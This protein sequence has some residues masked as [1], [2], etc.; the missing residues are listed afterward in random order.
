MFWSLFG[1][2]KVNTRE[3][4]SICPLVYDGE[5]YIAGVEGKDKRDWNLL[6]LDGFKKGWK[7]T[8]AGAAIGYVKVRKAINIVVENFRSREDV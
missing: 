2:T 3:P 8:R 7:Q 1:R 5:P 4:I 6:T